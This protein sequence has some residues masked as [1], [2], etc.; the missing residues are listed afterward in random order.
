[1]SLSKKRHILES[2]RILE[3]RHLFEAPI[4]DVVKDFAFN[5]VPEIQNPRLTELK[6]KPKLTRSEQMEIINIVKDWC[7]KTTNLES[8]TNKIPEL[9]KP[10]SVDRICMTAS[11]QSSG[12]IEGPGGF[13]G[14][15]YS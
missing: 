14:L 11:D 5:L 1:M 6:S 4:R 8:Y 13:L 10:I 7:F 15:R 9:Y 2:N 12:E 3:S